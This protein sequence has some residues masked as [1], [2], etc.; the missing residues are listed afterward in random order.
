MTTVME[1]AMSEM[2][3]L[4]EGVLEKGRAEGREETIVTTIRSIMENLGLTIKEA[5]KAAGVP[6]GEWDK[7][8]TL[9]NK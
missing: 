9:L 1:G 7:Y 2:C 6:S 3:N 4:G 8:T 5:L